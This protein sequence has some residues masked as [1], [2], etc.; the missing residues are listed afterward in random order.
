VRAISDALAGCGYEPRPHDGG[1]TLANCPFHNLAHQFTDLICGMN[2]D[3]IDG[4]IDQLGNVNL[5]AQ[6]DP[7][8]GRCCVTLER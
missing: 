5:R 2:L 1:I 7:A 8:P 3:L 4:L 6:L